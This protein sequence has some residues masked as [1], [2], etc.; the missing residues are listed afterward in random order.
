MNNDSPIYPILGIVGESPAMV[1]GKSGCVTVCF[2]LLC[3]ECYSLYNKDLD[4]RHS[5]FNQAFSRLP[6]GSWVHKQDSFL[7]KSFTKE[8]AGSFINKAEARHFNG[9]EYLEHTCILA[10]SISHLKTL[11]ASYNTNPFK[12]KEKLHKEDADKLS[13]FLEAVSAAQDVFNNLPQ[14]KLIPLKHEEIQDYI[15]SYINFFANDGSVNDVRIENELYVGKN[16]GRCIAFTDENLFPDREL[17]TS[18]ID[19]S[20][21]QGNLYMPTLEAIGIHLHCNHVYNQVLYFEGDK[22]LKEQLSKNVSIHKRNQGFDKASL[23]KRAKDL[24]ELAKSVYEENQTLCYSH[25]SL[26]FWDDDIAHLNRAEKNIKS[27]FNIKSFN[28][29]VPSYENLTKIFAASVLG[30]A[31]C[32]PKSYMFQTSLGFALCLFISYTTFTDDADGLFFNDR[33]FQIPLRK[34]IWDAKKKRMNA[35]NAIIIASTGG[36]KSFLAQTICQQLIEQ[37][38]SCV[39]CEYGSSFKQLCYLYP[40]KSLHIDYD[41]KTPL[42]INP[43]D[44]DNEALDNEKIQTLLGIVQKFMHQPILTP[45]EE[46]TLTNLIRIYYEQSENE[47]HSFPNFYKFVKENYRKLSEDEDVPVSTDYFDFNKFLFACTPFLPGGRYENVCKENPN[48]NYSLKEKSFIVFELTQ[49]KSD[50]FLSSLV[51]TVLFDVIKHKILSDK[52]KRGML[53][54]DEYAE[55]AQMTDSMGMASDIHSTVAFC[56]QKIR[57]ENGAVITIVQTPSQLPDNEFTKGIIA[58]TQ[59]LYVLPT[60]ETVYSSIIDMFEMKNEAQIN[61]M[62]S[63]ANGFS[64]VR[65]YSEAWIRLGENYSIVARLEASREK[66]LAFQTEGDI[67]STLDNIYERNGGNMVNAIKEYA[68]NNV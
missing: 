1:I 11:E 44:L 13:D 62:K 54:F 34:D 29:Y 38:Y 6:A 8:E 17:S 25:F 21:P 26:F 32:L 39:V 59:I 50:P 33:I 5:A 57:K 46:I 16:T 20:L 12:F 23:A 30:A 35:R 55:T 49:I 10:F 14:T 64:S 27:I 68:E 37:D 61:Q 2:R 7:V 15:L 9:R 40:E 66:F 22:K 63:I 31:P 52:S 53:I 47:H 67:R 19:S 28:F 65:P 36:G 60:T 58:N 48:Q 51:M 43:F 24:E 4:I 56:Y 18:E 42:G 45:E 3:P 41:G